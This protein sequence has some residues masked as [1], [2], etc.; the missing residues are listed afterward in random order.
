MPQAYRHEMY[1]VFSKDSTYIAGCSVLNC[2]LLASKG[3]RKCIFQCSLMDQMCFSARYLIAI[4]V[5]LYVS[6][7][8]YFCYSTQSKGVLVRIKMENL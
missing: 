5:L 2:T 1:G 4:E 3:F 8:V 6:A 7:D